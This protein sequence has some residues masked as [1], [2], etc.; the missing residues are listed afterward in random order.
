MVKRVKCGNAN[1]Y[2][3]SEGDSAILVD[4]GRKE[5]LDTVIDACK[6][7]KV[8]L[9]VLTH[10]HFDHA[11]NAAELSER[12]EVPI[13]MHKDDV[14]LIESNNNQSMSARSFLGKI[15]LSASLDGFTKREMRAFTPSVFLND[16]DDLAEY[17]IAAKVIGLPGHTKGSIG[18]DVGEKE[19]IAGDALMNIFYPTLSMLY[20]DEEAM[21]ESAKKI[22]GLGERIFHFDH[23][24][25]GRNRV[26]V[27]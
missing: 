15:V 18:I 3:V 8:K 19:L 5:Y 11:E 27:K 14:D 25:P 22:T 9:I 26:W 10:A 2:I 13:A 20:N 1:V 12:L 7:C 6:P 23:G 21:L 4:T 17:G 24:K 16:G